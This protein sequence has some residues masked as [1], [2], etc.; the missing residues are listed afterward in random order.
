M[1]II[2]NAIEVSVHQISE[3][4][5]TSEISHLPTFLQI[6]LTEVLGKISE[7]FKTLE[8]WHLPAHQHESPR[9]LG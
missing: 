1:T 4:F 5:K 6:G 9:I 2:E 8:I 3:V 7:V